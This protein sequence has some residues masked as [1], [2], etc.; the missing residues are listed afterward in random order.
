MERRHAAVT[1]T[2]SANRRRLLV[3]LGSTLGARAL[4]A[5]AQSGRMHRIAW[6]SIA[7]QA[8]T[9]QFLDALR[10]GL[11]ERGYEEGRN[12]VLDARWADHS[13][14]RA[15]KLAAE[16]A[17]MKPAVIVTQGIAV[18]AA[19]RLSPPVPVVFVFSADPVAAGY[20]ESY[21][22]PGRHLTGVS[23]LSLELVA[24][25]IQALKEAVPGMRRVAILAN[26]QHAGEHREH[27][28][29]RAAADQLGLEVVYHPVRNRPELDGT[30]AR[31]AA[32]RP[33]G[34]VV[35][36]DTLIL[37]QRD[38]LAKFFLQQRLPSAA[39]WPLFAESGFLLAYAAD[40]R[41]GYRRAAHL[42]DKIVRGASPAELPIELPTVFEL[43]VNRRTAQTLGLTLPPALLARADRVID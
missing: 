27:A 11:R 10:E 22:R 8:D 16:I 28:A 12:L 31:L 42:A 41:S 2:R 36:T 20:A 35:F 43:V 23:W 9:E 39:G 4:P 40:M 19:S 34:A 6:L 3:V 5:W 38:L 24:K 37:G 29:A 30:L 7:S 17:E 13:T 32:A 15:E 26:P 21:V 18:R 14:E 25:R 33:D 1:A